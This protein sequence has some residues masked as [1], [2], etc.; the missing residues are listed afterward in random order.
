MIKTIVRK[1]L[2]AA[3]ESQHYFTAK[4]EWKVTK[5]IARGDGEF[6]KKCELCGTHLHVENFEIQNT[7]NSRTLKIGSTC[8]YNFVSVNGLHNAEDI[9]ILLQHT[10]QNRQYHDLQTQYNLVSNRKMVDI[11]EIQTFKRRLNKLL[12]E[13]ALTHLITQNP[14]TYAEIVSIVTSSQDIY[15][16]NRSKYMLRDLL[17]TYSS[18]TTF[19]KRSN[20]RILI[21]M[22]GGITHEN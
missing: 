15:E 17:Y 21:E 22:N 3:S 13:R 6:V 4:T 12:K 9:K 5:H 19:M 1:R 10:V 14:E 8:I 20:Y 7:Q 18:T 2:L 16:R 11:Q